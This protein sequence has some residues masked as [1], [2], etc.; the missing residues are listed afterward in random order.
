MSPDEVKKEEG[1]QRKAEKARAK[2]LYART[3]GED[4]EMIKEV[5]KG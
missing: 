1:E 2:K 4:N 3:S 5:E